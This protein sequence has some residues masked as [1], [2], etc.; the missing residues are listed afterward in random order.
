M[1]GRVVVLVDIAGESIAGGYARFTSGAVPAFSYAV[2]MPVEV[3][4][5]EAHRAAMSRTLATL[6]ELLVRMGAPATK[7]AFGIGRP[8]AIYVSVDAPWQETNVRTERF[9]ASKPFVFTQALVEKRIAEAS[10]GDKAIVDQSI[11]GATV[12]GYETRYPYGKTANTATATILSSLLDKQVVSDMSARLQNSFH[13]H[14]V[15][16]TTGDLLRYYAVRAIF[17]HEQD[18]LIIDKLSDP[19][20]VLLTHNNAIVSV[21]RLGGVMGHAAWSAALADVISEFAVQAPFPK[22]TFLIAREGE[23]ASLVASVKKL[24]ARIRPSY[25]EPRIVPITQSR[26]ASQVRP[27]ADEPVPT[28][29]ALMAVY[30]R[31]R[32]MPGV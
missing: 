26:V 15:F 18:I 22:T 3:R 27:G 16:S 9:D 7:R 2:E 1:D 24:Y 19:S 21:A 17:P 10:A 20:S 4:E 29:L 11:V 5:G 14:D 28:A 8:E 12:N 30:Y 32:L 31:P 25:T 6:S 23:V 13:T